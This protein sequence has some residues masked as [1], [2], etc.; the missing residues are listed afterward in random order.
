MNHL[1]R[2]NFLNTKWI[3]YPVV[4]ANA[5]AIGRVRAVNSDS[6]RL[7][8]AREGAVEEVSVTAGDVA[9]ILIP[10]DLVAVS[11]QG[12]VTLLAPLRARELP[13][14]FDFKTQARWNQF[15]NSLRVFFLEQGFLEVKTPTLVPCPGTE[16]SLDVFSTE[17]KIGS[18]RAKFFLP[19]SPELHLKKLLTFG[20]ERVFEIA[21]C[22]RNGELTP[23]HQP[24]FLMLEWYRAYRDLE[25]IKRDIGSLIH[26]LASSL[27]LPAPT[28][29]RSYSVAELFKKHC[30]FDL[31][32]ETTTQELKTL[33]QRLNV[34]VHSA[35]S[36]DDFFFLIFLE[37]IEKNLPLNELIFVEKYPPYQAALARLDR[38]GWGER[39][40]A[41]W[42]GME[43]AN[44]FHELNDPVQQRARFVEDLAKKREMGKEEIPLDEEF[45]RCL[46]AGMPPSAG[47]ALG[48]ERLFMALTGEKNISDV[49]LF[50]LESAFHRKDF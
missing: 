25:S 8:I 43:L 32:P 2:E 13:R 5:V 4:P 40:E 44:A 38:Q 21:P 46:E 7:Q 37:R 29:V 36:I 39:F 35:Q 27:N 14:A 45:L 1:T 28:A 15:L 41:Y 24:E 26:S 12:E 6:S 23:I 50:P 33:A 16:P 42:K 22:F 31:H 17:F 9:R 47:V 19:T 10:G 18:R 30:D 34:D 48:I 49:R 20:A 3:P 11:G